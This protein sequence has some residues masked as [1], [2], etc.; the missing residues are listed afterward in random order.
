MPKAIT[1]DT[2]TGPLPDG[3]TEIQIGFLYSENYPF[4]VS[5]TK[6]AA[7]I[8][9]LL[10][11]AIAW[12]AGVNESLVEIRRL[13]PLNTLK[14]MGYITTLAILS[15]PVDL[16]DALQLDIRM[17]NAKLYNNPEPLK[18]NLTAQINP[19]IGIIIGSYSDDGGS[20][21]GTGAAPTATTTSNSDPFGN[22]SSNSQSSTQRNT[23]I[24]IAVG[25]VAVASAYGAAMFII[26]RRYKRKKQLH[27]RAS[28]MSD[29]SE[30]REASGSPALMGGALLSRDFSNSGSNGGYGG[31]AGGRDS[32]GSG[33]SGMG[34]SGRTAFISAPV[35]AENS[36][37]WN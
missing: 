23:T 5:N 14:S 4:I 19:A 6:A 20:G 22:D 12:G 2:G 8:F 29:P 26:A 33:R 1:P 25:S 30:M 32:Q 24:G 13:A 34:N 18:Y 10:P 9:Q 31:V 27:R 3:T 36:L 7:Q 21:S 37:G 35:A 17:P 16:V 28:S 11:S 15:F